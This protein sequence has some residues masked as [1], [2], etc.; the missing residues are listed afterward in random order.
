MPL[1]NMMLSSSAKYL[2]S[3]L[4]HFIT[5]LQ[6]HYCWQLISILWQICNY[7]HFGYYIFSKFLWKMEVFAII[8]S[9]KIWTIFN[10]PMLLEL[11]HIFL[12]VFRIG[13]FLLEL[14]S[15]VPKTL[16]WILKNIPKVLRALFLILEPVPSKTYFINC[17][18]FIYHI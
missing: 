1:H 17:E 10:L 4:S 11:I 3:S 13:S 14:I 16:L 7:V 6:C 12:E 18:M 2:L 8:N 9:A 15:Y 5:S